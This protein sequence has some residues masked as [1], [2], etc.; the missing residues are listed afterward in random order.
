MGMCFG[1]ALAWTTAGAAE[2]PT[3]NVDGID[4][5]QACLAQTDPAGT[6]WPRAQVV[7]RCALD[8]RPQ[9]SLQDI[10]QLAEFGEVATLEKDFAALLSAQH[11][12]PA[13]RDQLFAQ[14]DVFDARDNARL[15][16]ELWIDAAPDSAFAHTAA[17]L[18]FVAAA[19]RV[20][21]F[22]DE[23]RSREM[24]Y[25]AGKAREELEHALTLNPR[26]S[27]ACKGLMHVAQMTGDE[28]LEAKEV[29][30]CRDIDPAS[31]RVLWAW[32]GTVMPQWGGRPK[33]W[34]DVADAAAAHEKDNP[35]LGVLRHTPAINRA[36]I[37][38]DARSLRAALDLAP[39][40]DLMQLLA[41]RLQ[42]EDP[43]AALAWSSQALRFAPLESRYR[44]ARVRLRMASGDLAGASEDLDFALAH[45]DTDAQAWF[46]RG[47]L[48]QRTS[49]WDD[50]RAAY[51]SAMLQ[52]PLDAWPLLGLCQVALRAGDKA[53]SDKCTQGLV[54]QWSTWADAWYL[55]AWWLARKGDRARDDAR[56][57]F[58][59]TA[60]L[61]DPVHRRYSVSLAAPGKTPL[62][63]PSQ[64]ERCA[65]R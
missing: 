21:N 20:S 49:R 26:L 3:P 28:A 31:Y 53:E 15:A 45:D 55:R 23:Q 62:V 35:L 40:T 16:A 37:E 59:E 50:A 27:P 12:D 18:R 9:H 25:L 63:V 32:A 6:H 60:D 64:C 34:N 65:A 29:A 11:A 52:D 17:G 10:T 30:R 42:Y 47:D 61:S 41:S 43:K 24:R 38:G 58:L 51:R 46:L 19:W 1:L 22:A 33:D 56:Q 44:L 36:R 4:F 14:F 8:R 2:A 5:E 57:R 39:D 7:A 48:A 54:T 13:K